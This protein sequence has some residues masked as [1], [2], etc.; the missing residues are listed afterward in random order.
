[1]SAAADDGA[2]PSVDAYFVCALSC[3]LTIVSAADDQGTITASADDRKVPVYADDRSTIA[4]TV[5]VVNSN[6]STDRQRSENDSV[7][8]G[9]SR[10]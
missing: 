7:S 8:E 10:L 3:S 1:V 2:V 9:I 4:S 5:C 6:P